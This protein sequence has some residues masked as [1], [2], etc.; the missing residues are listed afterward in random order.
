MAMGKLLGGAQAFPLKA[1]RRRFGELW[2]PQDLKAFFLFIY[3][4]FQHLRLWIKSILRG[5]VS[6]FII[7][8]SSKL[9]YHAQNFQS[10]KITKS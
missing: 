2:I 5:A 3:L 7:L 8:S 9:F 10:S 6:V 1:P 4:F